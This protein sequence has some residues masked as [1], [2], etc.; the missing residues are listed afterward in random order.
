MPSIPQASEDTFA[1][2]LWNRLLDGGVRD[3]IYDY[4][5]GLKD[6]AVSVWNGAVNFGRQAYRHL[7]GDVRAGAESRAFEAGIQSYATDSAV[8]RAV[9]RE[10]YNQATD[11]SNY[12]ARNIGRVVGRFITG[13]LARPAGLVAGVGDGTARLEE[14]GNFAA[15]FI[16]GN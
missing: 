7:G 9:N 3:N 14:G 6:G 8:R 15:G 5:G 1:G 11:L 4:G 16:Y 10:I 2:Y 13:T 12:S